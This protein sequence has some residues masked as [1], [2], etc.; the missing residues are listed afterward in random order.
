MSV[1]LCGV[2]VD[3]DKNDNHGV[4]FRKFEPRWVEDEYE[5]PLIITEGMVD[6]GGTSR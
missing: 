5:H 3:Y 6:D 2:A 4:H 1:E